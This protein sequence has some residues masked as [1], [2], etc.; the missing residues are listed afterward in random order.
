MF[1]T[2]VRRGAHSRGSKADDRLETLGEQLRHSVGAPA[3]SETRGRWRVGLGGLGA[4]L[5]ALVVV[6]LVVAAI[7]YVAVQLLRP[8]PAAAFH[9][10]SVSVRLSGTAPALPW[11]S[12]GQAAMS[13]V[14]VGSI[15][16]VGGSS[17]VP[18][19]SIIKVL[20]AYVVLQDHPLAS[21]SDGPSVAVTPDV[22]AAYAQGAAD[23]QSEV[24]VTA[25]ETLNEMQI[26]QGMLIASGNDLALLAADWD[27]GSV[28]AFLTKE[29]AEAKALGLTSTKITD[30]SGLDSATVSNADDLVR[31]GEL[32]MSNSTLAQIVALPQV[33]LP[34]VGLLYNYDYALGHDG[35]IGIKTG[36]DSAAGGCFLFA[37]RQTIDGHPVT[38]V[39]AVIGQQ[40][41]TS[42]MSMLQAALQDAEALVS[43]V[44]PSLRS[45]PLVPPGERVG[46]VTAPWGASVDV[47]VPNAPTVVAVPGT[48]LAA[49]LSVSRNL[50]SS[51]PAGSR[52][53]ELSI[54]TESGVVR[55]PLRT[56]RGLPGPSIGWRLTR[57]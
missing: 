39:G 25:G 28:T 40:P 50:G 10:D 15:G 6:V 1:R 38:V 46:T 48:K 56:V 12:T 52:V 22:V 51:V 4:G 41:T 49:T 2:G 8:I 32:A 17:A 27:A 13:E 9:A 57:L 42:V 34:E 26:L 33:T 19:A 54:D 5:G 24:K 37:A 44:W 35:I 23:Q 47:A 36:S 3:W 43:A 18:T 14:G 45:L 29:N 31:L 7:A 20:T 11:P 55:L 30:P 16:H 21:G 53:G